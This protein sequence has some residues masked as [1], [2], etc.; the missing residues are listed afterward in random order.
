MAEEIRTKVKQKRAVC[1]AKSGK[2]KSFP[3]SL[4]IQPLVKTQLSQ[5]LFICKFLF[6]MENKVP[7]RVSKIK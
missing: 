7:E 5:G 4:P 1:D 6:Y 2:Q 3:L